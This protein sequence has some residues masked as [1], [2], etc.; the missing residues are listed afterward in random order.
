MPRLLVKILWELNIRIN[1]SITADQRLKDSFF[2]INDFIDKN[3]REPEK[4][5]DIN[6]RMLFS[7][8]LSLKKIMKNQKSLKNMI[9]ISC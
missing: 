5:K 4:S 6:E 1:K 3:G 9:N 8:L 7:R 2:E